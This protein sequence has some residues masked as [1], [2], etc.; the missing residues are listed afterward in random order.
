MRFTRNPVPM[1]PHRTDVGAFTAITAFTVI[2]AL[3]AVAALAA[4]AVPVPNAAAQPSAAP[5]APVMT[6]VPTLVAASP[7]A[8]EPP[9]QP[10]RSTGALA[11]E[12]S[13]KVRAFLAR[14]GGHAALAVA[15]RVTGIRVAVNPD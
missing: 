13:A 11:A 2:A 9:S 7:S 14:A 6:A 5:I 10:Q 15:D 3:T 12:A 4:C 1:R 8:D